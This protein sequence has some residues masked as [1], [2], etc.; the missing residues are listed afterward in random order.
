MTQAFYEYET[1]P[2]VTTPEIVTQV[3]EGGDTSEDLS[4]QAI[5]DDD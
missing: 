5:N 3:D 4:N 1:T 2:D